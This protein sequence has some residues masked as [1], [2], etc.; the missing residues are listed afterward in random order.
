MDT[1]SR[2]A[3]FEVGPISWVH[4]LGPFGSVD[5]AKQAAYDWC[6]TTHDYV[7]P[8]LDCEP[9]PS[10]PDT[11]T[12]Y[13]S[14]GFYGL[15]INVYR[16]GGFHGN[17]TARWY[18]GSTTDDDCDP[19]VVDRADGHSCIDPEDLFTLE[20]PPEDVEPEMCVGNPC[21]P[22]SG[23][24][25][26]TEVDYRVAA[27][28]VPS[29]VRYYSSKG[30]YRTG[31]GMP[32][33]WRHNYTKSLDEG[34]DRK[35]SIFFPSPAAD[36]SGF[37]HSAS[38]ACTQGW[39]DIKTVAFGGN[40]SSG[41]AALAGGNTC[42]VSSGGQT[43]AYLTVR[44]GGA[45]VPFTPPSSIKT[46]VRPNGSS[47]QFKQ[48]GSDWVAALN[49]TVS[50]EASGSNWVFTDSNDTRETYD[51]SGRLISITKRNG[52]TETLDYDLTTAQGGDDDSTTLDRVTGPFG[53]LLTFAYDASGQL[54]TVTT[55][56][57]SITYAFDTSENLSSVTYPDSTVKQYVYEDPDL[58]HHLTGIIDE[59]NDRFATWAYDDAG[60]A[61]LSEHAGGKESVT[62]TY[63]GNGTTTINSANGASRT[64][65]FS[66]EA[67]RQRLSSIT[68]DVCSD[69]V[70]GDIKSRTYDAN[71]F[72][73]EATDWN[74]V[75]TKTV[76]NSRGLT[77]TLTE[78]LGTADQRVTTTIWHAD[79]RLPT[80]VT[81]PKNVTDTGHDTDGNPTSVT[82]TGG[83]KTRTWGMTYNGDGQI[84]TVDGPRTDVSDVTTMTYHI[85]ST[86]GKCGQLASVTNALGHVTTYDDYDASGRLLEMTEP[87]GLETSF[88]YDSRGN[89]LTVT[90]TPVVG[91]PITTTMTYDDVGQLE[92][93]TTPEGVVLTYAYTATHYL[94]SVTDNAGNKISYTYDAM[95][96][97]T[98]E[99]TYDPYNVLAR[100]MDY[101]YGLDEQ[102]D[103]ITNGSI[104]TTLAVDEVGNLGTTTDGLQN[105][106]GHLY[107][108]LN[109]LDQTT[110]AL[111][112]VTSYSYDA[113]DNLT[114]VAAPNSATTSYVYDDLD[115]LTSETS[116]DRGLTS[117]TH[118]DSG[119]VLTVTD[120]RS[121]TA[122][123]TYDA[124][125]R[126][127]SI[128]YPNSAENVTYGYDVVASNGVG[129][130]TSISDQS[131]TT[132]YTYDEFGRIATDV[133]VIAGYT[134]T[135]S[136][137]YDDDGNIQSVTYPSGRVVA[138]SSNTEG[139]ITQVT[140]TKNSVVKT[141]ISSASYEPF[142]PVS[143]LTYGNGVSFT[144]DHNTDYTVSDITAT[145][146]ADKSYIY[147]L[148]GNID[149]ISDS[150]DTT[151]SRTYEYD[152]LNR[153]ASDLIVGTSDYAGMILS[154]SPLGYWR[155]GESSGTTAIDASGN[156]GD[157]TYVGPTV[158][159]QAG[160]V[161]GT[162]TA[163]RT[164]T[165]TGGYVIGP[166]LT[167]AALTGVEVWF[168]SDSLAS[169]RDILSIYNGDSDRILIY[170]VGGGGK[171]GVWLDNTGTVLY[172]DGYVSPG[173]P[174]HLALWYDSSVNTTYMMIDGVTQ[175]NTYAGNLLDVVN[176][177]VLIGTATGGATYYPRFQGVLDEVAVYSGSVGGSM[178][179]Q[180]STGE[181]LDGLR[182]AYGANGNRESRVT[183]TATTS[184][185][186]DMASNRLSSIDGGSIQRD[187]VG[188]RTAAVGGIRTYGYSDAN[189]LNEVKDSGVTAATYVHNALGQRTKKSVG[190]STTIFL[191]DLAG[192][193]LAEHDAYGGLIRDYVWMNG[194]P[195]A[196]IDQGEDF[197]YL[198]VDHLATPRLAT[199]DA[200]SVVWRWDGD[201]FGTAAPDE[202]P[203][204]DLVNVQVN[205]RFPGQYYDSETGFHY[206]YYRNYD[207]STGRYLESDPIGLDGG[208]N[209]YIYVENMPTTYVD[210][211][212][213]RGARSGRQYNPYSPNGYPSSGN[214]YGVPPLQGLQSVQNPANRV[215]PLNPAARSIVERAIA[216]ARDQFSWSRMDA[217]VAG[218]GF[219]A[220]N[221]LGQRRKLERIF[222]E[223]WREMM[224]DADWRRDYWNKLLDEAE[225]CTHP[226]IVE[227]ARLIPTIGPWTRR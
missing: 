102:L 38:E 178:F 35:P 173:Q 142:G 1:W 27:E 75:T 186:Y 83:G 88:T 179:A 16:D 146:I 115:N 129:R 39:N 20:P 170:H 211:F 150:I 209:T 87:N 97:L 42:E 48:V 122:T 81:T 131:G 203:D 128:N 166:V 65:A 30:S 216:N 160:L 201:A 227:R 110:D 195:V 161:A 91:T 105:A 113:H 3:Q 24:K 189:R 225:M 223:M 44:S 167:G 193:L 43:K 25:T 67:G 41:T 196:Q 85:C 98:D 155:L 120:A 184:Y 69:C 162:N 224:G 14:S 56:D 4:D 114:S 159:G 149:E 34:P 46:I 100:S 60:R 6:R 84:L 15:V 51:S 132:T 226:D 221:E 137:A 10:F 54:T 220:L 106:T 163:L 107:D 40:L 8:G 112:G 73:D 82:I 93:L 70:G 214:R 218:A 147:D 217:D 50:L 80:K 18:V 183:S 101:A 154:D 194:T 32:P 9:H 164:N 94:D 145:S 153:L 12:H 140:S 95:G 200:Q 121:V 17:M 171:I 28:G 53:H 169:H 215:N 213:L 118:D 134:Y 92:T 13:E 78:A 77:E 127:A 7:V 185:I 188:N 104:V 29:F 124:L 47:I 58:P 52:Q 202:D 126:V 151:R 103:S 89:V 116:P 23:N 117:Y 61:V 199:D 176:P 2:S 79:F 175:Q 108:A 11:V 165:T 177:Q 33:G 222:A 22:A 198:H 141:V 72:L 71:G 64:Y 99:D 182:F 206:N 143:N 109:R 111:S 208:L 76:R 5:A 123:Y 86:G 49:G 74:N 133:R 205:L 66:T 135:T 119:N 197:R 57:G 36:Q 181:A 168:Q 180:H 62:L 59:N 37:Y 207:P 26:Q 174:H 152:A 156:G 158:L 31:L 190:S 187:L 157:G 45:W 144:Y 191:Y 138:Y 130:L 172:S 68:G 136:Y 55:P 125:N 212:G 19:Q 90:Q 210:P 192:N 63:N 204:Q 21:D 139:E 148:A 219:E 96:N